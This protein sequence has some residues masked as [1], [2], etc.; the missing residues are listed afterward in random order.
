MSLALRARGYGILFR[1]YRTPLGEI[2]IIAKKGRN[3]VAFEVKARKSG[4]FTT[5][6]VSGRQRT[7]IK[8]AMG[9]FLANNTAYVDYNILFGTILFRSIFRF[10]IFD[11][12]D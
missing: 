11:G 7:R 9:V 5:E 4:E 10:K 1:R 8:N 12:V 3:L 2:D 6:L